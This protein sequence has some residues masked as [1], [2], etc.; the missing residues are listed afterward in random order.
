MIVTVG[1]GS[2]T[3]V[4]EIMDWWTSADLYIWNHSAYW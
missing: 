4:T 3:Y 2:W 1:P